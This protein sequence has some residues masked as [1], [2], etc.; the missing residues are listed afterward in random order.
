MGLE[1]NTQGKRIEI[2]LQ[3]KKESK[4]MKSKKRRRRR[5]RR[6][7]EGDKKRGKERER[8]ETACSNTT[9]STLT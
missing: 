6:D 7:R 2:M 3:A 1:M 8:G 5:R 9:P 4:E